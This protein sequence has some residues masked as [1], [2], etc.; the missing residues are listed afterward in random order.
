VSRRKTKN[1]LEK[2]KNGEKEMKN[3]THKG[4]GHVESAFDLLGQRISRKSREINE[5][6][7]KRVK[8]ICPVKTTLES[9]LQWSIQEREYMKLYLDHYSQVES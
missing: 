6:G 2:K 8:K 1:S 3:G 5:L 4:N 9:N 7:K